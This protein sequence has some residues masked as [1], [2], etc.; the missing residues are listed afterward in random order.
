MIPCSDRAATNAGETPREEN[1][2]GKLEVVGAELMTILTG[3]LLAHG[4][5]TVGP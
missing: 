2:V 4:G 3:S 1:V 5:P